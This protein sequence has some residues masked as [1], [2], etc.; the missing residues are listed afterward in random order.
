MQKL[1]LQRCTR[2]LCRIFLLLAFLPTGCTSI[3]KGVAEALLEQKTDDLRQCSIQGAAFDGLRQSLDQ[4][5]QAGGVTKVLMVHGIG[6]H[7]PG[8]ANRFRDG[9]T[10]ALGLNIT[11]AEHKTIT[12]SNPSLAR[13]GHPATLTIT[14][15]TDAAQKRT[16]LFYELTWAGLTEAQK[17]QLAYDSQ[18]NDGLKRAGINRT[19][20]SFINGTVP[21]MLIY[22]GAGQPLI[23]DAVK[24]ATCWMLGNRWAD[25]PES[26]AHRCDDW[27]QT[28]YA[29]LAQDRAY[30]ITHSLGSLITIDTIQSFARQMAQNPGSPKVHTVQHVLRDK[31]FTVF[32]LSNQLPLLQLGRSPQILTDKLQDFCGTDALRAGQRILGQLRVVAISDPNDILS[33]PVREDFARTTLDSRLC[34]ELVN[35]SMNV[36]A[37]KDI[38]G[39]TSFADP[40]TAHSGYLEDERV[41]QLITDGVHAGAAPAPASCH[42]QE[43]R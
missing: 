24:Q 42:W 18:N 33:Y 31:E 22:M 37:E 36:A 9:I 12:I 8:Y 30:F 5:S 14:R 20:K 7:L 25:L 10:L 16:L 40:L 41:T 34:T 13:T 26:G 39:A 4:Q 1:T 38:F 27:P 21:D 43:F 3:S 19:L 2:R 35:V 32:M 17:E 11:N 23:T 15:H 6:T 29:T 28:N